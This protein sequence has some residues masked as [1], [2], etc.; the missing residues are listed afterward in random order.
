[1][2]G[3]KMKQSDQLVLKQR[4]GA[5]VFLES[6]DDLQI[7]A[8]RW[9]FDE[10]QDVFFQP[11]DACQPGLGG[12]GCRAV[13]DLVAQ[14]RGNGIS[15][16]GIVD[17]DV[18]LNDN[19]WSLWWQDQDKLFLDARPYGDHI[20]ILLRWELE[21]YLL[22]LNAMAIEANDAGMTSSHTADSIL[23]MCLEC[24]GELKDKSAAT[25]AAKANN[26]SK[27]ADAFGCNPHLKGASLTNALQQNLVNKGLGNA[28]QELA[29]PRAQIDEFDA[30]NA[31][32]LELRSPDPY[33]RGSVE[34]RS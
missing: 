19:N 6:E 25:V 29:A 14:A 2:S 31:P 1:M 17:R 30:P 27:I 23:S 7:I 16:F 24:S 18:L 28:T 32:A 15:A 21:N 20:R 9:F 3:F 10:G 5:V 8:K 11:A 12:G 22:D 4:G 26:L 33:L 13:I 34:A